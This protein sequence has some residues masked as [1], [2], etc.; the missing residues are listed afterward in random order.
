MASYIGSMK[1]FDDKEDFH[2]YLDRH[3]QLT[4][5]NEITRN[6]KKKAVF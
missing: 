1:Q 6:G 4:V 2:C 5:A 3:E